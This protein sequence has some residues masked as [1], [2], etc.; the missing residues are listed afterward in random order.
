MEGK[1]MK[2]CETIKSLMA[3]AR[4]Y[5]RA[6]VKF[7]PLLEKYQDVPSYF[8]SKH[9]MAL[10]ER[11][12]WRG[13]PGELRELARKVVKRMRS[14][15]RI[16]VYV[17]TCYRSPAVQSQLWLDGHSELKKG[18][19]QISCA[20]DIVHAHFH[21][22]A[23]KEFWD[24]LGRVYKEEARKLGVKITWGGDWKTLYDPA[25][26]ELQNWRQYLSPFEWEVKD[27]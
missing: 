10:S 23:G 2:I 16:P 21:W 26:C 20:V 25:H 7:D 13:C 15:W 3:R 19:H 8:T 12:D 14:E 27:D 22:N 18:A 24:L 17:H 5:E 4:Q 9:Y 11:A 1:I 6:N